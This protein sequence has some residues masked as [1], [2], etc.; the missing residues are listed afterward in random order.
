[1]EILHHHSS[2]FKVFGGTKLCAFGMWT[3]TSLYIC[4]CMIFWH[5]ILGSQNNNIEFHDIS[6]IFSVDSI[7]ERSPLQYLEFQ[8]MKSIETVGKREWAFIISI[9]L[10]MTCLEGFL[11]T[12]RLNEEKPNDDELGSDRKHWYES[13]LSSTKYSLKIYWEE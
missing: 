1:M 13:N 12:A 3:I 9:I 7:I 2:Y 10:T 5:P 6:R 11:R 8:S 4:L